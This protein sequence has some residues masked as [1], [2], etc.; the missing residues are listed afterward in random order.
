MADKF[1]ISGSNTGDYYQINNGKR[2]Y[3]DKNGNPLDQSVFLDR[4]NAQI[5][6]K[7]AMRKKENLS[8]NGLVKHYVKGSKTG[9]YYTVDD[10]GNKAYY[11]ADGTSLNETYFLKAEGVTKNSAG[12]IVKVN[13]K[14]G[15]AK[16]QPK[17]QQEKEVGFLEGLWESTKGAING[18]Y[19]IAKSAVTDDEGNFD[20]KAGAKKVWKATKNVF[21][22][23]TGKVSLKGAW[24]ALKSAGKG[25]WD[26]GAKMVKGM[27]CNPDGSWDAWSI[28]KGVGTLAAFGVAIWF[29]AP[30]VAA[31]LGVS[32]A[33][34]GVIVGTAAA[35]P[36]IIE[37]ANNFFSGANKVMDT[38]EEEDLVKAGQMAKDAVREQSE[39]A[40]DVV[41]GE[42][43]RRGMAKGASHHVKS[44][45]ANLAKTSAKVSSQGL[46]TTYKINARSQALIKTYVDGAKSA[47]QVVRHPVK[48]GK[49]IGK[50][51]VD[52]IDRTVT[53]KTRKGF[54][55]R[56]KDSSPDEMQGLF[57]EIAQDEVMKPS[58][59]ARALKEL[60]ERAE[61]EGMEDF[62]NTVRD[63]IQTK[64]Y[65]QINSEIDNLATRRK[66]FTRRKVARTEVPEGKVE[67][68]E[69]KID[70]AVEKGQI[71]ENQADA[72]R[73]KLAE[74]QDGIRSYS[75]V[76]EQLSDKKHTVQLDEDF[77]LNIE[78]I[79]NPKQRDSLMKKVEG[80][81]LS[82]EEK[83]TVLQ[84]I[85]DN[86]ESEAD[87]LDFN[88]RVR[89]R[90]MGLKSKDQ[91]A[92]Q[93]L[94]YQKLQ[95]IN[96]KRY[97][98]ID[99]LAQMVRDD[100]KDFQSKADNLVDALENR[101][102][103]RH[104]W[105]RK[106]DVSDA[107]KAN[108]KYAQE[109]AEQHLA[110]VTKAA[111]AERTAE[112]RAQMEKGKGLKKLGEKIN[113]ACDNKEITEAQRD[114][115]LDELPKAKENLQS[116]KNYDKLAKKAAKTKDIQ[117]T[118][119]EIENAHANG[120]IT[121]E[122]R[123]EL[124][125]KLSERKNQLLEKSQKAKFNEL[126]KKVKNTDDVDV[127]RQ[128]LS[129]AYMND[130][131]SDGQ[132]AELKN[133]LSQREEKIN[134]GR[135]EEAPEIVDDEII[136]EELPVADMEVEPTAP[137]IERAEQ[138][139]NM[140]D[141]GIT[142]SEE[143][144]NEY[145]SDKITHK[146]YIDL[147]GRLDK[148]E[149]TIPGK[150]PITT[151]EAID[152]F[153][154]ETEKTES[155]LRK[156]TYFDE[157]NELYSRRPESEE[158]IGAEE[159]KAPK[160]DEVAPKAE[161]VVAKAEDEVVAKVEDD[162]VA[163][164]EDEVV[165][166]GEVVDETS[167]EAVTEA[168]VETSTVV[169]E[170]VP[171]VK[172]PELTEKLGDAQTKTFEPTLDAEGNFE[173]IEF[174][175]KKFTHSVEQH[176]KY[177][178]EDGTEMYHSS[179]FNDN[180]RA[181]TINK[182]GEP[183]RIIHVTPDNNIY[184]E[185]T[186]IKGQHGTIYNKSV[187]Y[188]KG[189]ISEIKETNTTYNELGK[190]SRVETIEKDPYGENGAARIGTET[191]TFEYNDAGKTTKRTTQTKSKY[192]NESTN[193]EDYQYDLQN[194][195][196]G[197]QE[198]VDGV[199]R[200]QIS[201]D[202]TDTN[203]PK[204]ITHKV[205]TRYDINGKNPTV[206]ES[207]MTYDAKSRRAS[208]EY[209][210]DGET[211]VKAK[212]SGFNDEGG[213]A[214]DGETGEV[215]SSPRI[216]EVELPQGHQP[217]DIPKGTNIKYT[218]GE[219]G[220]YT[221]V[222]INGKSYPIEE[223]GSF[224]YKDAQFSHG[225]YPLE[226]VDSHIYMDISW[227]KKG[228][229]PTILKEIDG[230]DV[231]QKPKIDTYR[232]IFEKCNDE[233]S[234]DALSAKIREHNDKSGLFDTNGKR[235][236]LLKEIE[237]KKQQLNT[238][239]VKFEGE[240]PELLSQDP[241]AEG[242]ARIDRLSSKEDV[243][244]LM[245]KCK[246]PDELVALD[247][248]LFALQEKTGKRLSDA[249][250]NALR[251]ECDIRQQESFGGFKRV[252]DDNGNVVK[253]EANGKMFELKDGKY[254][255][256]DNSTFKLGRISEITD[257]QGR[258]INT[259][260]TTG[261][262]V[263]YSYSGNNV[264]RI[265]AN[266]FE[267][268]Y[269]YTND[270]KTGG[271]IKFTDKADGF[272]KGDFVEFTLKEDGTF[273]TV[274]INGQD[275]PVRE[276]GT[277]ILD[278]ENSYFKTRK[279]TFD[280]GG[281]YSIKGE[282]T[283]ETTT[284][285][286]PEQR[287]NNGVNEKP[288]EPTA[289]GTSQI[290]NGKLKVEND[291]QEVGQAVPDATGAKSETTWDTSSP[292]ALDRQL[293]V[294]LRKMEKQK[295]DM[296]AYEAL[297]KEIMELDI[298]DNVKLDLVDRLDLQ[299]KSHRINPDPQAEVVKPAQPATKP[300]RQYNME[301]TIVCEYRVGE[302]DIFNTSK[303]D[304]YDY[305][306]YKE[307][308]EYT[309]KGEKRTIIVENAIGSKR[310]KVTDGYRNGD[311]IAVD[312]KGEVSAAKRKAIHKAMQDAVT[313][314]DMKALPKKVQDIMNDNSTTTKQIKVGDEVVDY[315]V[316]S[317]G[318]LVSVGKA[319][320]QG[321]ND[322][323]TFT[324]YGDEYV[325]SDGTIRFSKKGT[326]KTEPQP[327]AEVGQAVSDATGAKPAQPVESVKPAQ[328]ARQYTTN[329]IRIGKTSAKW[330]GNSTVVNPDQG[331][332]LDIRPDGHGGFDS[333]AN[334]T[335]WSQYGDYVTFMEKGE[336]RTAII[337]DLGETPL[338]KTMSG[339][340]GGDN[341]TVAV[342]DKIS[343]AKCKRIHQAIKDIKTEA[344]L[345]TLPQ[346][347]NEILNDNSTTTKQIKVGDTTYDYVVDSDGC[348]VKIGNDEVPFKKDNI[349]SFKI[350]GDE[351]TEYSYEN[352]EIKIIKK[353]AP[354]TEPTAQQHAEQSATGGTKKPAEMSGSELDA[355]YEHFETQIDGSEYYFKDWKDSNGIV[356]TRIIRNG[357]VVEPN[358]EGIYEINGKKYTL[359]DGELKDVTEQPSPEFK[360][361]DVAPNEGEHIG[362][363]VE[364][365]ALIQAN[366]TKDVQAIANE[367]NVT[368][369][370]NLKS[371]ID[372]SDGF[373]DYS[374]E[375][376]Q[377]LK[378]AVADRIDEIQERNYQSL[379]ERIANAE[380]EEQVDAIY[381][382][383]VE[384]WK[385][386][387][388]N[389]NQSIELTKKRQAKIDEI[390]NKST[391]EPVEIPELD[392]LFSVRTEDMY[393][394]NI[395]LKEGKLVQFDGEL[396]SKPV[397]DGETFTF[398]GKEYK[399]ENR[400]IK[401]VKA[402]EAVSSETPV[403]TRDDL[404]AEESIN[405]TSDF[406]KIADETAYKTMENRIKNS[407]VLNDTEKADL[408]A[409]LEREKGGFKPAE[410]VSVADDIAKSDV[411]GA[412]REQTL[413]DKAK[414]LLGATIIKP[415]KVAGF[416]AAANEMGNLI[417]DNNGVDEQLP[418]ADDV[419]SEEI[420]DTDDETVISDEL[421]E[422]GDETEEVD[423]D[424]SANE[425]SE[426]DYKQEIE[427]A[428]T[429]DELDNI[430]KAIENSN[431]SD[432]VKD[433][434]RALIEAR[435]KA[436]EAENNAADNATTVAVG[437]ETVTVSKAGDKTVVKDSNGNEIKQN[438]DGTY[439][440]GGKKY[441]YR[442]GK[443]TP[444]QDNSS[445]GSGNS[446]VTQDKVKKQVQRDDAPV[447]KGY[448]AHP[449]K[450]KG[451][452]QEITHK[453]VTDF[454]NAIKQATTEE[455][456]NQILLDVRE[457]KMFKGRKQLRSAIKARKKEL[458]S[459]DDA[460]KAKKHDKAERKLDVA[461]ERYDYSQYKKTGEAPDGHAVYKQPNLFQRYILGKKEHIKVNDGTTEQKSENNQVLFD[462]SIPEIDSATQE[463]LK[464]FTNDVGKPDLAD[465][466]QNV[467]ENEVKRTFD[468]D[469]NFFG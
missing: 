429:Q 306:N 195:Q 227:V 87:V 61:E 66:L 355:A 17:Q 277:F 120:D 323:F 282:E 264:I 115:L 59:K 183:T 101:A 20:L 330:G 270:V 438:N 410:R 444:V 200:K 347:V 23:E 199:V 409:L 39:G 343:I 44:Y 5:D 326:P 204:L 215:F 62:A 320:L 248:K 212:Y 186:A 50:G 272:K 112:F 382:D 226:T 339:V 231:A 33:T 49:A 207:N 468:I 455:E 223:D 393:V 278:T 310:S 261:T 366:F 249:D 352:G 245:D 361:D 381:E 56:I 97:S 224:I 173:T 182:P 332:L 372:T 192:G 36:L 94:A 144:W 137:Q 53:R 170:P 459:S 174:N 208:Y 109:Y 167:T 138:L 8:Q 454:V 67:K 19:N 411:D 379:E 462:D 346:K 452:G 243:Q 233:T 205:E 314:A 123:V 235:N 281:I 419:V 242:L 437:D 159:I 228:T 130:E 219:N 360:A 3:F 230:I 121:A 73:T 29:A 69:T 229:K 380:T 246:T 24:Q 319:N 80:S 52:Y 161:E 30:V 156:D 461:H 342:K 358:A 398:K 155:E 98:E 286:R 359:K 427:G 467:D 114:A 89:S 127:T 158:V 116:K 1:K 72:L 407:T 64:K 406:D 301:D 447:L 335:N 171:E 82:V 395:G 75:R 7:G 16:N 292:E 176:N 425:K 349:P 304:H 370:K 165:A 340:R 77:D 153:L 399:F 244:A 140:A 218:L 362:G 280:D 295:Y 203:N 276:D 435:R 81:K 288:V 150:D 57:E 285:K 181:Y 255:A 240:A 175:G 25:I 384:L 269:T 160:A 436:L 405:I 439:T 133:K 210:V 344:E 180:Y 421:I 354:K 136:E 333:S 211:R 11:A 42:L 293:A 449:I 26:S 385:N 251:F 214:W 63:Q 311:V 325:F 190:P 198:T 142:T 465:S 298:E 368:R 22:D 432:S 93:R 252:F 445:S 443:F 271:T 291:V 222:E 365:P 423:N 45:E 111:Q 279:Y 263:K 188:N 100:A 466:S 456:L 267:K 184:C 169:E 308:T 147:M 377:A 329:D 135:N 13:K 102:G 104:W 70:A 257:S 415:F 128:E 378:Q 431:L 388:I 413:G 414:S 397:A 391:A 54:S 309:F 424:S 392:E 185:V 256:E 446:G 238:V 375:Q 464:N 353:G 12:E 157:N 96:P 433:Q 284:V 125:D 197:Y 84:K 241:V 95:T 460:Y 401:E 193:V 34:A 390:N 152:N 134:K 327:G 404:A 441:N 217:F 141:R 40:T 206:S 283:T 58:S 88:F 178:A 250:I 168:P 118:F 79:K 201:N 373:K 164:A 162:V 237:A 451:K 356:E 363:E 266:A 315:V 387:E 220:K 312:V 418:I 383:Q 364:D 351:Y 430:E 450:A 166:K 442:D 463:K 86:C 163:K 122:Q 106:R 83:M 302:Q 440:I 448:F 321:R 221:K 194:R 149:R 196:T 65:T 209:K 239:E 43:M 46:K 119:D 324:M 457:F 179:T 258:E 338:G 213:Y 146:Q 187:S 299:E 232:Q 400:G 268:T 48:T 336:V 341:I 71:T 303:C 113:K 99:G 357:K 234:L 422:R 396:L 202:F 103:K 2:E 90:K 420:T 108:A 417:P 275:I 21:R 126:K 294:R 247:N 131:I 145:L 331:M 305:R 189:K 55:E 254:V 32:A 313:D 416:V 334:V 350:E 18:A 37:G 371:E 47:A 316:D 260:Y 148:A 38:A 143:L 322:N 74:Q 76:N 317:D 290:E 434:I 265:E 236:A 274:K 35:A 68:I 408:L 191:Q 296:D 376:K 91:R 348:L 367:T 394:H 172:I 469:D 389:S 10:N 345:E 307:D 328:P 117:A 92:L 300:A 9:R 4:N 412:V 426:D 273:K 27:F 318:C 386:D 458:A 14:N 453:Q 297:R 289:K 402:E 428:Q 132:Y 107:E 31:A 110:D 216:V 15:T 369:L 129:D 124:L 374:S 105:N 28:A 259:Y 85:L 51:T 287:V 225:S 60:A 151:D 41:M 78:N 154:K 253:I 403:P 337:Q 139:G 6:K 262:S 177:I